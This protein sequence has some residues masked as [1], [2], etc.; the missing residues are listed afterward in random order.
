MLA[1][2][3]FLF[4]SPMYLPLCFCLR[5]SIRY[6]GEKGYTYYAEA[7]DAGQ[8]NLICDRISVTFR[9][10]IPESESPLLSQK[11]NDGRWVSMNKR[12]K[13]KE[14]LQKLAWGISEI[15]KKTVRKF[16]V[17]P[18]ELRNQNLSLVTLK[19]PRSYIISIYCF[20]FVSK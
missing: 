11:I 8:P 18:F 20:E 4:R 2:I 10:S 13:F 14:A 5:S 19:Q 16:T 3:V 6:K 1:N 17:P 7:V 12:L 9:N 15:S